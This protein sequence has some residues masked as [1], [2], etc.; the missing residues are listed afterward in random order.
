MRRPGRFHSLP[1][2]LPR[3]ADHAHHSSGVVLAGPSAGGPGELCGEL[4]AVLIDVER[5]G[6]HLVLLAHRPEDLDTSVAAVCRHV[7]AT[8]P[9][10]LARARAIWGADQV[11]PVTDLRPATVRR[12]LYRLPTPASRTLARRLVVVLRRV[13]T[14]WSRVG[15]SLRRRNPW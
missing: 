4:L 8:D 3:W 2:D 12:A 9:A 15:R 7:L 1:A 6:L 10:V 5:R 13:A 14:R 11:V